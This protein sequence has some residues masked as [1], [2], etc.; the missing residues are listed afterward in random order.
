MAK[1]KDEEEEDEMHDHTQLDDD[2]EDADMDH[3]KRRKKEHDKGTEHSTTKDRAKELAEGSEDAGARPHFKEVTDEILNLGLE[4]AEIMAFDAMLAYVH[5][6]KYRNSVLQ[7]PVKGEEYVLTGN[8]ID[9]WIDYMNVMLEDRKKVDD[10][11]NQMVTIRET[12]YG[13]K[14]GFVKKTVGKVQDVADK[15]S[16]T[17]TKNTVKL[18]RRKELG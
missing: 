8:L 4:A 12:V 11:L 6:I 10:L 9:S 16:R 1:N 14:K 18:K 2:D 5:A 17:L 3:K 7:G 13:K 15:T